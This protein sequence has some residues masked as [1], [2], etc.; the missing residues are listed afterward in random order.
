MLQII[1]KI[2]AKLVNPHYYYYIYRNYRKGMD[3]PLLIGNHPLLDWEP[4]QTRLPDWPQRVDT[5]CIIAF[6]PDGSD[7]MMQDSRTFAQLQER[8]EGIGHH[9]VCRILVHSLQSVTLYGRIRIPHAEIHPFTL[10]TSWAQH[11]F[12]PGGLVKL[13]GEGIRYGDDC[14]VRLVLF[15]MTTAAEALA[16][17]ALKTAHFPNYIRNHR[18]RTRITWIDADALEGGRR[19]VARHR[20]LMDASSYRFVDLE[21]EQIRSHHRDA[22]VQKED[23]VD[24]EWEFVQGTPWDPLLKAKL[25]QWSGSGTWRM[26][27]A[28]AYD[29]DGRNLEALPYLERSLGK[30]P[31][32]IHLSDAS[33][34]QAA[35]IS[36][37][38]FGMPA[39]FHAQFLQARKLAMALNYVYDC[40][41]REGH[42]PVS[43]DMQEAQRQWEALSAAHRAASLDSIQSMGVK[44][45]SVG[46]QE[47]DWNTLYGMDAESVDHLAQV[48]HNR[49]SVSSLLGGLRPCTA[50]EQAAIEKDV[51][52]RGEFKAKGIHYDLR[53]YAELKNDERGNDTR[54]YDI[55]LSTCIPLIVNAA[56]GEGGADA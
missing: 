47:E 8:L 17:Q 12:G 35:R 31:T 32:L 43:L 45:R 56:A 4:G 24:T 28:F 52:R 34:A 54:L 14:R 11:L 13:D 3:C 10:E 20:Q 42:P 15:G 55:A 23:Y 48:E 5:S 6:L 50:E 30:T 37:L 36:A 38:P 9:I 21:T 49:W 27:V 40:T 26:V 41:A 51:S 16:L 39:S 33:L 46:L 25:A 53:A 1:F 22:S 18:L 19:F 29:Q 7:P 2:S 44:M